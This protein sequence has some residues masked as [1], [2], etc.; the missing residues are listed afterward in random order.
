MQK[1]WLGA[2]VSTKQTETQSDFLSSRYWL[3]HADIWQFG[4]DTEI[5]TLF[6][7]YLGP[8]KSDWIY[9]AALKNSFHSTLVNITVLM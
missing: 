8:R 5:S 1:N 4:L 9:F 6:G 2:T 3:K 7:Q